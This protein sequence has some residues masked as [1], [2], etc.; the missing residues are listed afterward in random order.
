VSLERVS[1][2]SVSRQGIKLHNHVDVSNP[3][4]HCVPIFD[5]TYTFKSASKYVPIRPHSF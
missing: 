4:L 3:Y 1:F 2:Q 5:I